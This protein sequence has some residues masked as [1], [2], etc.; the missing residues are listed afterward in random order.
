MSNWLLLSLAV[1]LLLTSLFF[2]LSCVKDRR[3][4][5]MRFNK[6]RR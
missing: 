3:K 2:G 1:V 5:K 4:M 6:T